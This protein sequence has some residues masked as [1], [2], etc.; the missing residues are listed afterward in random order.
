MGGKGKTVPSFLVETLGRF[1]VWSKC[2]CLKNSDS[3]ALVRGEEISWL[4]F[5]GVV[6][7]GSSNKIPKDFL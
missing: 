6:L 2:P 5:R 1:E 4:L 7:L 3:V